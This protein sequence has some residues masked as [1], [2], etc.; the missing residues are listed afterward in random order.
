[1]SHH[2]RLIAII[3]SNVFFQTLRRKCLADNVH[4]SLH[5]IHI[6]KRKPG[7]F[8]STESGRGITG[9][10]VQK[11]IK[12]LILPN[13]QFII[14][15]KNGITRSFYKEFLTS[16]I[17]FRSLGSVLSVQ[18]VFENKAIAIVIAIV[19]SSHSRLLHT[20]HPCLQR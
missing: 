3:Q 14:C 2:L 17:N 13:F 4:L 7:F 9:T 10:A 6:L 20:C 1:M 12:Y 18:S 16:N 19:K 11:Y 5:D 15:L 8:T